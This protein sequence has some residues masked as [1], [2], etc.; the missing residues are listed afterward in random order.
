MCRS[1]ELKYQQFLQ[2]QQQGVKIKEMK[3]GEEGILHVTK[4]ARTPQ[5]FPRRNKCKFGRE[6]IVTAARDD[7]AQ[8]NAVLRFQTE[9][10]ARQLRKS[11]QALL[12]RR[13]LR[14]LVRMNALSNTELLHNLSN[15]SINNLV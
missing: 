4:M 14:S 2:E 15:A 12:S 3:K 7:L 6:A 5:G 10:A 11:M 9:E 1:R 8:T 13:A